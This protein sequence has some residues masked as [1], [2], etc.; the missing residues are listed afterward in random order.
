MERHLMDMDS[1][2]GPGCPAP[3]DLAA[4]MDGRLSRAERAR[5][6]LHLADCD[7]CRELVADTV[8]LADQRV[9]GLIF[10]QPRRRVIAGGGAALALAASLTVVAIVQPGLLPFNDTPDYSP[11]VAAVGQNRT[12]EGRL[13]G[14]FAY[15]PMK[16]ATRAG[17][18]GADEDFALLAAKGD[19]QARAQADPTAANRHAA[20]VAQLV[21]GDY[22]AAIADLEAVVAEEPRAASYNDLSAAYIARGREWER[23][24]DLQKARSAAE[25][26]IALDPSLDEAY[27]NRALALDAL[28]LVPEAEAAYRQALERDPRSPWNAEITMRL[29]QVRRP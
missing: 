5:I 16:R 25:R 13:T 28:G 18:T 14:G 6:E 12:V 24:E 9:P 3:E 23:P 15:A 19:L 1:I 26:A 21:A 22:E 27:F 4:Y 29:E 10:G 20:G 2:G 8:R 11:L 7:T 17:R